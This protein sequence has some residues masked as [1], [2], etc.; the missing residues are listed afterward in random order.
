MQRLQR[1]RPRESAAQQALPD[2]L[3]LGERF[4]LSFRRGQTVLLAAEPN[5]GKS[6]VALWLSIHWASSQHNLRV[7]YFSAD[8]DEYTT[9]RRSTA[10]V[11]GQPQSYVDHLRS[12][13]AGTA[14]ASLKGRVAFDF[15]TD[16]T[17]QHITEETVAF[18]E[19][20][21]Q[22]PDVIVIDN[23]MDVVGENEDEFAA[24]IDHTRA[25]KRLAR[26][27]NSVC[28]MLHHC[29][30][31]GGDRQSSHPPARGDITGKVSKKPEAVITLNIPEPGLMQF[32]PVKNREGFQD[33]SGQTSLTL[34]FDIDRM[35]ISDLNHDRLGGVA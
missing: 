7:L 29:N 33:K 24:L 27:T 14:L 30:E 10:A 20:W 35:Q 12:H 31:K 15:E 19:L 9:W 1:L 21:G 34:R 13:E 22:Y 32:A 4:N 11:L 25:F 26:G 16:P 17:Y 23:L 2:L 8:S 3:G 28:L 18:Y 6:A 5:Q